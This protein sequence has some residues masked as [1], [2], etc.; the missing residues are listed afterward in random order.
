VT[1]KVRPSDVFD[2]G[3]LKAVLKESP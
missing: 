1:R 3:L 2:F